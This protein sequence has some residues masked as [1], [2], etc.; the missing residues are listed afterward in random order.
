M[1]ATLFSPDRRLP[2]V[3]TASAVGSE[4]PPPDGARA[5]ANRRRVSSGHSSGPWRFEPPVLLLERRPWRG[6][7]HSVGSPRCVRFRFGLQ[8]NGDDPARNSAQRPR[9]AEDAGFDIFQVGDHV[10]RESSRARHAGRR[11]GRDHA[12]QTGHAGAQ[13]RPA[14]P[15]DPGPGAGHPRPP[16]WRPSRGRS[17]R[18]AQ[19]H[20]VRGHGRGVRPAGSAQGAPGR[21]HRDHRARS[22]AGGP[23]TFDGRHYRVE[24]ASTPA[25]RP[26]HGPA[27]GRRQREGGAGPRGPA[28]RHRRPHHARAHPARRPAP[29]GA[30]GGRPAGRHHGIRSARRRASGGRHWRSTRWS[31]PWWRRTTASG[32]PR[33]WPGGRGWR[34]PTFWPPRS[35]AWART[36]RWRPISWPAGNAGAS[37]YFTRPRPRRLRPRH[38]G[39]LRGCGL[40]RS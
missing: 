20:R 40:R 26:E 30:V 38:A 33:P 35:S 11:R 19:L 23:V 28:R 22:S 2:S 39:S 10:G 14:P 27:P 21:G 17:R 5:G 7:V 13:Q 16:E 36:K 34:C 4:L 12:H 15:G 25:P 32:R 1:V 24:G 29:R 8:A 37:N 9:R 31:R 3:G 6:P 18:R